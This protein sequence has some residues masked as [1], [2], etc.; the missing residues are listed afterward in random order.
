MTNGERVNHR[1]SFISV[2]FAGQGCGR[3][4]NNVGNRL[5]GIHRAYAPPHPTLQQFCD[6][7]IGHRGTQV[8]RSGFQHSNTSWKPNAIIEDQLS[9]RVAAPTSPTDTSTVTTVTV[10][11]AAISSM[12]VIAAGDRRSSCCT[13]AAASNICPL[14][15]DA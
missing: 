14:W 10:T 1:F 8:A 2:R 12:L 11:V 6:S 4:G 7:G 9:S 13:I 15:N 3:C 5:Q